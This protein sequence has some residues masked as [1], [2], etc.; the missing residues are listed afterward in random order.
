MR[1]RKE[2]GAGA[3]E[4]RKYENVLGWHFSE[5]RCFIMATQRNPSND[6]IFRKPTSHYG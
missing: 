4:E 3:K 5:W 6:G 2:R 1:K